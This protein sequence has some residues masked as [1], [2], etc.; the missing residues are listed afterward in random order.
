MR[1]TLVSKS[2]DN[3]EQDHGPEIVI[4]VGMSEP[5]THYFDV[6]I[7][8]SGAPEGELDVVMPVWTPGSYLVREFAR[9]VQQFSSV[10]AAG[11][12]LRWE[13]TNKNTW[14][15]YAGDS[16]E[17]TVKY[18]VYAF[19]MSVRTSFL[20]DSHAYINGASVFMYLEGVLERPYCVAID[21]YPGWNRIS[22]GLDPV[23]GKSDAFLAPDFDTLVDC[24]IEIGNQEILSFD[25]RGTPHSIAIYGDGNCDPEKLRS[26]INTIVEAATD[27]FGEIPYRH[28]TFIVHLLDNESGGLEHMNSSSLQVSRWC[29]QPEESYRKFLALVAHEYFHAW[30]IKRIRPKG[31]GPFDYTKE[32]Y[33]RMLWV[34]EGFTN[35]YGNHLVLRSGLISADQYLETLSK[36]ISSYRQTPGRLIESAAEASFDAWIKFYRRDEHSPNATISYYL[37]GELIGLVMELEI[38]YRTGS[39]KSLDDVM[40]LLYTRFY[41]RCPRGFE[42]DEFRAACE[43]VAGGSLAEIFDDCVNGTREIDFAHYLFCAGLTFTEPRQEE[44]ASK[45]YLGISTKASEGKILVTAVPT[46]TP[47][48]NHGINVRD[49]IV[50][51]DGYRV[52]QESLNARI[53]EKRP[54]ATLEITV[55]R[56]GKLRVL[57]VVLGQKRA[58]YKITRIPSPTAEQKAL[59]QSWLGTSWQPPDQTPNDDMAT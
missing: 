48:Y 26:D 37:K 22:T 31:L 2:P 34:S 1:M 32:N 9:N 58:E 36:T 54:G 52:D 39:V 51:V 47:G 28:Y 56:S 5:W 12:N 38:R 21:P 4:R 20:D 24:P 14:R 35:Y 15:V 30:N 44:G 41:K 40:R 46:A 53:E 3:S 6:A 13:K 23:S 59:Y 16:L 25:F 49:E 55:A 43:E 18:R 8:I 17:V 57:S 50:A 10:D 11:K 27:V 29:F 19:E 33:T 45:G 42:E 7:N